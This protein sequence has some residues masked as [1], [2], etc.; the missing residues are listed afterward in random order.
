MDA[1]IFLRVD[2]KDRSIIV[3]TRTTLLDA[4]RDQLG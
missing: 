3:D 2:G 4:L 1:Q